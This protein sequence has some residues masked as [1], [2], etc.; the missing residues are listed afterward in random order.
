MYRQTLSTTLELEGAQ[1]AHTFVK[2]PSN[3]CISN[4]LL[5]YTQG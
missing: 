1:R 3:L 5:T 4:K 2:P